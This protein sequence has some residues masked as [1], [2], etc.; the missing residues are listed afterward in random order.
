MTL[1]QIIT[2]IKLNWEEITDPDHAAQMV[3]RM[4]DKHAIDTILGFYVRYI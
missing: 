4:Q 3:L 2:Y 1:Q